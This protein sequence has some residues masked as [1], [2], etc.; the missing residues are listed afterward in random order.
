MID[1]P[2]SDSLASV[3]TYLATH[4]PG[5][6]RELKA[7]FAGSPLRPIA[8]RKFADV[9]EDADS[10]AGNAILKAEA[11][12]ATLREGGSVANVL[13]D[14]SGL[15][16]DALAGGPGIHSARYG[17]STIAWPERRAALLAELRA[18]PPYRRTARFVCVLAF[19]E[20]GGE[21]ITATGQVEGYVLETESGTGGFGYDALFFYPPYGRSFAA[22]AEKEKNAVSHRRRAAEALLTMLRA[23]A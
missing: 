1:V 22:L 20:P 23:R 10:Y 19:I 8:P 12:A 17:G 21:V 5:K 2:E 3:K 4:N 13:A 15:E 18:I 7:V 14:D 16:V 9:V 6:L 11:L